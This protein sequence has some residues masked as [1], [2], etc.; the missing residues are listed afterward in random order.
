MINFKR[1][2][3]FAN[4]FLLLLILGYSP[5]HLKVKFWNKSANSFS[6]HIHIRL[7]FTKKP[8]IFSSASPKIKIILFLPKWEKFKL[9]R[10]VHFQRYNP[11]T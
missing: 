3:H 9:F 2:L 11:L 5:G 6:S 10:I 1:F 7:Q 8:R 4:C